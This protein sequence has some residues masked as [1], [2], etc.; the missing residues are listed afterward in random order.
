[1]L[2]LDNTLA[3]RQAAVAAWV[4]E[5]CSAYDLPADASGWL[6]ELDN[7]G[8]SDR[9]EV[10]Q[11]IRDRY[12]LASPV[13]DLL[14][15][16][17]TRVVQLAA[18]IPG[19][20]DCLRAMRGLGWTPALVTNGSSRQQHAKIDTLGFRDL[21]AAVVVSGDLGIKKPAP[22]IF[23]RAA[24][25]TGAPLAGAWMVGDSAIHDIEGG[26]A[27]GVNTAWVTRG[28]PW[29]DDLPA[30]TVQISSLTELIARIDPA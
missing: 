1:M 24:E 30:P 25:L 5:F 19:A 18:P 7:D 4:D 15:A 27:V 6:L 14:E 13:N 8:Y 12:R 28:R 10:F 22:E 9:R 29:P 20:V 21:V 23:H 2:D 3:D 16:Y 26:R 11:A 17:Q